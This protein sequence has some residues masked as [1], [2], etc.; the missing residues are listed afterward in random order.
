V[1]K[2]VILFCF[3][4][5]SCLAFAEPLNDKSLQLSGGALANY[6][7]CS[8]IALELGDKT[9]YSYYSE[10]FN[11]RSVEITHYP[12][13]KSQIAFLEF[14]KSVVKLANIAL[15]AMTMICLKRLDLLTRKMQEKKLASK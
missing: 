7:I 3:L 11:D 5:N 10:M 8:Q 2:K 4:A 14:N 12:Q 13:K 1:I 15:P 9:M 6:Q